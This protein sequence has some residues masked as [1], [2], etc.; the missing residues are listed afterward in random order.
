MPAWY[1]HTAVNLIVFVP[2][3]IFFRIFSFDLLLL[4]LWWSVFIDIDHLF[5]YS[6]KLRTFSFFK[7]LKH[8]NVDFKL[9]RVHFYIFHTIEFFLLFGIAVYLTNFDM[10]LSLLLLV[11][12]IHLALDA[13]RHYIKHRNFS[14]LKYYSAFYYFLKKVK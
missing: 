12:S 10:N 8:S 6:Y 2:I 3:L 5:Y 14:W 13:S 1:V 4:I 11:V 9:D 7:I